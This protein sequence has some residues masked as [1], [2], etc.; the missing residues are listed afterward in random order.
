M[1]TKI[2]FI[3]ILFCAN[4]LAQTPKSYTILRASSPITIDSYMNDW[5]GANISENFTIC[6]SGQNGTAQGNC[7]LLW[8]DNNL[9]MMFHI[10]DN[11]IKTS[12]EVQDAYLWQ[13][14]DVLEVIFD[15]DGNGDHYLEMGINPN[16][17]NYDFNLLCTSASCGGWS[18]DQA[19]DIANMEI[20]ARID[21]SQDNQ[22]DYGFDV[23]VK[24]PFNSF[25]SMTG[26]NFQ[27]PINGTTWRGNLMMV[28]FDKNGSSP[29]EYLS[30]STY[31][32]GSPA[33]HQPNYFGYFTFSNMSVST[34]EINSNSFTINAV[35]NNQ[36]HVSGNGFI[37]INIFDNSGRLIKIE[38]IKDEGI[39]SLDNFE[40]GLYIINA[41]DGIQSI[42]HKIIR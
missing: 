27:M 36:F 20:A 38:N 14:G 33:F 2:F 18:D 28:N 21:R 12:N 26:S 42:N 35:Q 39:I 10:D 25:N 7:R 34:T 32:G 22:D 5:V 19:W 24:I 4:I 15:F 13:K 31:P 6:T 30:W 16:G 3:A 41:S 1:K 40:K 9:Y 23:E 17:N 11:S 29:K 37:Q 8:D